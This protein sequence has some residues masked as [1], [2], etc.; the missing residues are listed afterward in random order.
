M[1]KHLYLFFLSVFL[2]SIN[3]LAQP[4]KNLIVEYDFKLYLGSM[5]NYHAILCQN[6]SIGYFKYTNTTKGSSVTEEN[7]NLKVS[8]NDS[9]EQTSYYDKKVNIKVVVG[10]G[11][12]R[13]Y[14]II[15]SINQ[16]KWVITDEVK[17]IEKYEAIKATTHFKGRDYTVWFTPE[18]PAYF[19]P[20]KLH[21]LPGLILEISDAKKEVFLIAKK[22]TYN[23]V[24]RLDIPTLPYKIITNKEYTVLL[25][26]VVEKSVQKA[27]TKIGR[28][29]TFKIKTD[30]KN[31]EIEE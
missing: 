3:L 9:T 1:K 16:V 11:N 25:R 14:Q 8:I 19:G 17:M 5:N 15:D 21:G 22:I 10:M 18:I 30:F 29:Y 24:E 6:D 4:K 12:E 20:V 28:G 26:Q 2:I 31:I 23:N 13:F 27:T 7:D